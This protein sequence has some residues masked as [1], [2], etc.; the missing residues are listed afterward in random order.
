MVSSATGTYVVPFYEDGEALEIPVTAQITTGGTAAAANRIDFST[1]DGG[2]DNAT[3]M[4][5]GVTNMGNVTV[6]T[7]NNSLQVTDRFWILDANHATKPAV[8]LSFTYIDAENAAPNTLAEANL[9]AQR[10]NTSVSD[11][12]GFLFPPVGTATTGTNIVSGVV[13]PAADFFRAWTLVDF[14]TPLPIELISNEVICD[15][16]NIVV[17]WTTASETNS[18][19]FTVE[20]SI[21]G[22]NFITAGIIAGGGNSTSIINYSFTDYNAYSGTSYYRLKQTDY[23][24]DSKTFGIITSQNCNATDVSVNAFNDQTGNISIVIDAN[25]GAN[26]EATLFDALGKKI[27]SKTL[28]VV[29]GNNLFKLD[30]SNINAGI[31]FISIENGK[32][33]T[34][35]KILIF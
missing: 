22:I 31:Y 13:V 17:K 7:A 33:K 12:D 20:K 6:P 34:T 3:Y 1:Y 24:G 8:T 32:E 25:I 26:Y 19:F 2:S 29:E 4:P 27:N 9:K 16:N 18:N 10:W 11:W 14:L 5:S 35:K 28:Q 30:V 21:D 15:D 23:N